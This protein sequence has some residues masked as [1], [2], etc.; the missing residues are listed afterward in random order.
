MLERWAQAF[1][2]LYMT[3]AAA[4]LGPGSVGLSVNGAAEL[5]HF[6]G[7]VFTNFKRRVLVRGL[8]QS[9]SMQRLLLNL[10]T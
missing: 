4:P 9:R 1:W 7:G 5:F 3:I 2:P 10:S 6:S 8:V